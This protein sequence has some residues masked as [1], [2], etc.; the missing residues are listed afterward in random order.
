MAKGRSGTIPDEVWE[1]HKAEI[2]S[3]YR[4]STLERAMQLMSQRHGFQASKN[5]Y[6][7]M[8]KRWGIRKYSSAQDW[9]KID[10]CIR[11]RQLKGKDTNAVLNG[12]LIS[13]DKLEKKILRHISFTDRIFEVNGG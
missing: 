8:L 3:L 9:K 6:T 1:R 2:A 10:S 4:G 12:N 5:Q 11:K 7:S 13:Q